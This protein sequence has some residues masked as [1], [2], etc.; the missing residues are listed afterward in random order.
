[1]P[2]V[3]IYADV[4]SCTKEERMETIFYRISTENI[5]LYQIRLKINRR[6]V[7]TCGH[8]AV[9]LD[10]YRSSLSDAR[11]NIDVAPQ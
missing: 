2:I 8:R 10:K 5:F 3:I 7:Q 9:N 6:F 11:S 4:V 1:M